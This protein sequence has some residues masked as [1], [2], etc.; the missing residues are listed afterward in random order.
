MLLDLIALDGAGRLDGAAK[1]KEFLRQG[2]FTRI[3]VGNNGKSFSLSDLAAIL[4]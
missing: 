4:V 2:G 1:Q 3:G